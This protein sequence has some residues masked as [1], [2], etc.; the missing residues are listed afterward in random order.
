MAS[1]RFAQIRA[2]ALE[3]MYSRGYKDTTLRA[4]AREMGLQAPSLYNHFTSKQELLLRIMDSIMRELIHSTRSALATIGPSPV[5]RLHAAIEVFVTFNLH[6]PHEAAVSDAEFRS[7]TPENRA[8]IVRLRQEFQEIFDPLIEEGI[9]QGVFSP[10][11]VP[12]TRNV[13]LSACARTYMWYRPD[14]RRD[15][16][17]VATSVAD[18]LVQGLLIGGHAPNIADG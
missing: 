6:H 12:I 11:D 10:T 2:I 15:A 7:L 13:I 9:A 3:A 17:E 16:A 14:G 8:C 18:Y 4:I 1:A 5:E